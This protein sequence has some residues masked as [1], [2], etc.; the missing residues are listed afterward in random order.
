M[1]RELN[2]FEGYIHEDVMFCDIDNLGGIAEVYYCFLPF[3]KTMTIPSPNAKNKNA[4]MIRRLTCV[5][6]RGFKKIDTLFETP[7]LD[8]QFNSSGESSD[9]SELTI[10]TLG[11]RAE[12]I[13][14]SRK[15]RHKP[16]S[17]IVRDYNDKKFVVGTLQSPAYMRSFEISPGK[18]LD[19]DNGAEIKFRSNTIIYEYDGNI[20]VV[21]PAHFGDF[22]QDFDRDFD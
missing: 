4:G 7:L 8:A 18:K 2:V 15:L 5:E 14:L 6:N 9:T 22:N 13:G 17:L 1:R 12:L 19:D 3:I 20:P 21:E 11:A 10:Y 16:F